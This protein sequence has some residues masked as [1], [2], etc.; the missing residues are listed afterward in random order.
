M[1][2]SEISRQLSIKT[3]HPLRYDVISADQSLVVN[4][5]NGD[6]QN[7]HYDVKLLMA[8]EKETGLQLN[9]SA[10]KFVLSSALGGTGLLMYDYEGMRLTVL[11]TQNQAGVCRCDTDMKVSFLPASGTRAALACKAKDLKWHPIETCE[12][13]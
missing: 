10:G 5:K 3:E 4:D 7:P 12:Q 13:E 2:A 1:N 6:E 11:S 8:A 9:K